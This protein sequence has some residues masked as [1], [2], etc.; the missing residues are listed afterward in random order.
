M[1]IM[2]KIS[3]GKHEIIQAD[4]DAVVNILKE[5]PITQG[6]VVEDFGKA[7]ADYTGAEYGI[8]VASGTA[9][10][11]LT[12]MAAGIGE[13]DEVITTPMT[14]CAT[15]NVVLHQGGT[16]RF[17]DIDS[18]TL[19]INT[20]LIEKNI[21][22]KTKA[23]MPVDFRG[24]PA[25]LAEIRRIA[26]KHG[27]T[28][29]EDGAH[30]IGSAYSENGTEYSCGDGIHADM[31]T[32]SFHP[33]KHITTG[34]GGA[35]LT[36][37]YKYYKEIKKLCKHGI[38]RR[39]EMFSESER[40]GNW[41]YE[42]ETLGLNYR[43]TE[44]QAALGLSQLSRIDKNKKRRR[45]IVEYYNERFCSFEELILPYES[46]NVKSNFHLYTLQVAE[47]DYFDRY[48]LYKY[49]QSIDYL[50]MVHYIPVHLLAYYKERFGYKRGDYPIA[51]QYY[52]RSISLPLY[53]TL[54]DNQIEKV[55]YDILSYINKKRK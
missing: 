15:S 24:H 54:T 18:N 51:E 47:N 26:D 16:V 9:A 55:V 39:D 23:I 44:I 25:D 38:D 6:L 48:D 1:Y 27:L 33:V 22:D 2:S 46:S 17:V 40:I 43:M 3:Y 28:I 52:D 42:M 36:N 32:F 8:A 20:D 34:E 11:H 19:N 35:I 49:L 4:I 10:L 31:C 41:K 5:G 14:F 53:P 7:L 29:I 21:T 30:S 12:V 50:P 37:N 45:E 13:G